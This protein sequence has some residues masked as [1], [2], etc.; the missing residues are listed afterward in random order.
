MTKSAVISTRVDP[1]L[2]RNVEAVLAPLGMTT[3]QA[4][5][6]FLKQIELKRG[7]PFAVQLPNAET[8]AALEESKQPERLQ[9]FATPEDLYA[10]L[11]I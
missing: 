2:K 4:I 9:R 6:L 1:E 7:L 3:T 8:L 11:G 5:T 10:D